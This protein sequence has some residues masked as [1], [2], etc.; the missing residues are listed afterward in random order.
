MIFIDSGERAST[1]TIPKNPKIIF[2]MFRISDSVIVNETQ[3]KSHCDVRIM[4]I[5]F[6]SLVCV[7]L[8]TGRDYLNT[9]I[10]R[11]ALSIFS[12][13]K[14]IK[15]IRKSAIQEKREFFF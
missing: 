9:K 4:I 12:V 10:L 14:N 3:E 6:N 13:N 11:R 15:V 8:Y 2:S 5:L 1:K 7:E